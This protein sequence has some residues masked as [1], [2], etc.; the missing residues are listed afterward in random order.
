MDS[1]V[2]MIFTHSLNRSG[3]FID[4]ASERNVTPPPTQVA[5]NE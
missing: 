3:D 5:Q 4:V 1:Y 2:Q